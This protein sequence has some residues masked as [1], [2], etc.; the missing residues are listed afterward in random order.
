MRSIS[1]S[2]ILLTFG[3][4]VGSGCAVN[5]AARSASAESGTSAI[6]TSCTQGTQRKVRRSYHPPRR[7][8]TTVRVNSDDCISQLQQ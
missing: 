3:V 4:A 6:T 2:L 7:T 5:E 1:S 8:Y